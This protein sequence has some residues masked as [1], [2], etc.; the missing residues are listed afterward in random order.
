MRKFLGLGV[1][2]LLLVGVGWHFLPATLLDPFFGPKTEVNKVLINAPVQFDRDTALRESIRG[3]VELALDEDSGIRWNPNRATAL[4]HSVEIRVGDVTEFQNAPKREVMVRLIPA[5]GSITWQAI[6]YGHEPHDLALSVEHGFRDGWKRVVWQQSVADAPVV[7]LLS[8]L[9]AE[10]EKR[11]ILYLI[12]RLGERR[13]AESV[14]TLV[15]MLMETEDNDI[16]LRLIGSLAQIGD[17]QA[18]EAIIAT[19]RLKD[20]LFMVQVVY[21][22]GGMGGRL[23]EGFLVTLAGGHP[24]ARVQ[25][26]ARRALDA[27]KGSVP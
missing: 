7:E 10:S 9:A 16:S 25:N 15:A 24:S 13:A 3:R 14:S 27:G 6:G 2:G 12:S 1:V 4:G 5:D 8:L 19:T 22:I 20:E 17:D 18:V 21:A 11:N 26:A 23:A